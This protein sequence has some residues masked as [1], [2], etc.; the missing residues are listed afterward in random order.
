MFQVSLG[1]VNDL[2]RVVWGLFRI[3]FGFIMFI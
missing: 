3:G 1:L 2:F